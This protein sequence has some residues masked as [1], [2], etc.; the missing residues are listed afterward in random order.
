[1][2]IQFRTRSQTVVDYSQY[3]TNNTITGCCYVYSAEGNDVTKT[4]DLTISECNLQ[5]GY[6]TAGECDANLNITPSSVGCCCAC[7]FSSA[8]SFLQKTTLCECQS[9]SGR[10]TLDS[11]CTLPTGPGSTD[12]ANAEIKRLCIS[13]TLE[14][15]NQ[16]DYR[17]KRACCH[18]EYNDD[19]TVYANCTDVCSEKE[20]AEKAVYPYTATFYNNGRKC[21]EQVGAADPA[22]D[23]CKISETN[24]FVL[25][26]CENGTNVFCWDLPNYSRCQQK[27][28]F[29]NNFAGSFAQGVNQG[30]FQIKI[31]DNPQYYSLILAPRLEWAGNGDE[32]ASTDDNTTVIKFCPGG[33]DHDYRTPEPDRWTDGYFAMINGNSVPLYFSTENFKN[34]FSQTPLNSPI[35]PSFPPLPRVLDLIAT[36][37]FSAYISLDN[38]VKIYGRFYD[39]KNNQFKTLSVNTKLKKLYQHNVYVHPKSAG[40]GEDNIQVNFATLG[41]VGQKLDN[42]FEYYSPFINDLDELKDLRDTIRSLPKKQFVKASLGA[43]TFCGIDADGIMTCKSLNNEMTYPLNKKYRLVSCSSMDPAAPDNQRPENDFCFAVDENNRIIKIGLADMEFEKQPLVSYTDILD[44]SC[45]GGACYAVVEPDMDVCNSQMLGSCCTCST[46]DTTNCAVISQAACVALGGNFT[47]GGRCPEGFCDA[48][49]GGDCNDNG[50]NFAPRI[51]IQTEDVLPTSDLTYYKDGLYIGIFEPG[52]PLNTQ[53]SVVNGNP[54]TGSA[55]EYIPNIVGYGTTKK[56]WAIIVAPNEYNLGVLNDEFEP[57]EIIPA[58]MYDGLWNTYGDNQ[59]Y[60]GIQSKSMENLRNDSRLSGWYLPSKNELEF[61]NYKLNHGFFIPEAFKSMSS[62]T[63]L[64]STPYFERQSAT[65][66]NIDS[67]IFKGQS[68]MFGQSYSKSNYGSIYLVPRTSQ[69]NV[70]LIRRIELE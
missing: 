41:F 24:T 67:Q 9:V 11:D 5:N 32:Y 47:S 52:V 59:T 48:L 13:G 57:T 42:S 19:G 46:G 51:T 17:N 2:S 63:Y 49:I 35:P 45:Y 54:T 18:P 8:T 31:K 66:Y 65:T 27:Q 58:S 16:L 22:A 6:F 12:A 64:T 1:M 33:Y 40:N 60:Y 56:R 62:G 7:S 68:F 70:R 15:S 36:K 26:S 30:V 43:N 14:N 38:S 39:A 23:E 25:N 53:G 28:W 44:I 3:I 10:W 4:P 50:N 69:V 55:V 20:C 61:I 21:F 29:D 34:R 37:T